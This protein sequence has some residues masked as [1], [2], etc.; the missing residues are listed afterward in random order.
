M[1]GY[2]PRFR[3]MISEKRRIVAENGWIVPKV[4]LCCSE[5]E[6]EMP[7]SPILTLLFVD[8]RRCRLLELFLCQRRNVRINFHIR[9]LVIIFAFVRLDRNFST[10]TA[11]VCRWPTFEPWRHVNRHE[12]HNRKSLRCCTLALW[13]CCCESV[14]QIEHRWFQGLRWNFALIWHKQTVPDASFSHMNVCKIWTENSD[15]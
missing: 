10:N 5:M 2:F 14:Q 7:Y 1:M 8:A 6:V 4:P 3:M 15:L 11:T 12:W 9:L 13:T